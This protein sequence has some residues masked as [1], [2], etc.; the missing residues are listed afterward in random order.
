MRYDEDDDEPR[1]RR[2]DDW[3]DPP[4]RK[5]GGVPA[6]AWVLVGSVAALVLIAAVAVGLRRNRADA[7]PS[8][9]DAAQSGPRPTTPTAAIP[10]PQVPLPLPVEVLPDG[11]ERVGV[12]GSRATMLMPQSPAPEWVDRPGSMFAGIPK[13]HRGLVTPEDD[14]IVF[15]AMYIEPKAWAGVPVPD[16]VKNQM[17]QLTVAGYPAQMWVADPGGENG[18]INLRVIVA[19]LK[20]VEVAVTGKGV[21]LDHPAAKRAL[22][23]ISFTLPP[24]PGAPIPIDY[25]PSWARRFAPGQPFSIEMSG[26]G[27]RSPGGGVNPAGIMVWGSKGNLPRREMGGVSFDVGGISHTAR[28]PRK[29][30]KEEADFHARQKNPRM[31]FVRAGEFGGRPGYVRSRADGKF[32]TV[33]ATILDTTARYTLTISGEGISP[34]SPEVRRC[35]DSVSFA[36]APPKP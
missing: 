24:K 15:L 10:Q 11:W 1:R 6:W 26:R 5:S 32:G 31:T 29:S 27:R 4:R 21:S 23:S 22:D 3:G 2:R 8:Q 20:F 9:P 17:R 12:P 16:A 34:D 13:V 35:L 7:T 19:E 30:V 25:D 18:R 36:T 28:D 33:E 14:D